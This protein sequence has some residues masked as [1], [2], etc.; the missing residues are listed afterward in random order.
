MQRGWRGERGTLVLV[1]R[2]RRLGMDVRCIGWVYS[3]NTIES[4][5][6][7]CGSGLACE[8]LLDDE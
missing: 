3:V 4:V 8:G 7:A 2:E 6:P 1:L 5:L